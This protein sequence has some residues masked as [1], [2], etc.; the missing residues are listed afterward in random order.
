MSHHSAQTSQPL[1]AIPNMRVPPSDRFQTAKLVGSFT[2]DEKPAYICV[3]TQPG[4]RYLHGGQLAPLKWIK[5]RIIGRYEDASDRGS[6][7]RW[8]L[9]HEAVERLKEDGTV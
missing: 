3:G 9:A 2:K 5:H 1:S 8:C 6:A 7:E 4:R